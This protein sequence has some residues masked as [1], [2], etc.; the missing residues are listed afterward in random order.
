M[1]VEEFQRDYWEK[2]PLFIRRD[3]PAYHR[4]LP[5]LDDV[6]DILALSRVT[7]EGV[8]VV[9]EGKET[10]VAELGAV[11]GWNGTTNAL[12]ALYERYRNGSTIV[13]NALEG[14]WE[15]LARLA[16]QLGAETNCRF[17]MNLY[18]TPA[19]NQGFTPHYDTHDVFIAQVH[20]TKT[21]RLHGAPYPL[22][23]RT[24]P[25]DRSG[26]GP[27]GPVEEIELRPGDLLYLPRGTIHSATAN[28]TA[29][30]HVTMGVHPVIWSQMIAD[31]VRDVCEG[32]AR[33]REGL[34]LGFAVDGALPQEVEKRFA[35]LV[36][37]LHDS[38]SAKTMV[39][40]SLKRA[41]SIGHPQLRHH[42]VDLELERADGVDGGTRTASRPGTRWN[43]T[44]DEGQVRLDFNNKTVRFPA[45]VAA[46]VRYVAEHAGAGLT[47][48]GIPGDLDGPGRLV[49]VR[50]LLRE[51]FLTLA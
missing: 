44:V 39:A 14:R 7:L 18:L 33:F 3:D 42:L 29:S 15:P 24:Q 25:F 51:G 5:T 22:P 23:L 28:E 41:A 16:A 12:E 27:D 34:P 8:R 50:T 43:L 31:A 4:R 48:D 10:P 6:D 13:V 47:A 26:S 21:W 49:L 46:E 40:E 11:Q 37:V 30:V 2:K 38:L 1:T 36:D 9:I 17:Q 35:E 32:D 20:G 45:H 19:G